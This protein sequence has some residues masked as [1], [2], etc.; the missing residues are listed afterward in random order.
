MS[1]ET[2]AIINSRFATVAEVRARS[3]YE[4]GG[5]Q[6]VEDKSDIASNTSKDVRTFL[7]VPS[8]YAVKT[9]RITRRESHYHWGSLWQPTQAT[10]SNGKAFIVI[11]LKERTTKTTGLF[12]KDP[13]KTEVVNFEIIPGVN[14]YYDSYDN[15]LSDGWRA[16][17]EFKLPNGVTFCA[18]MSVQTA[19]TLLG[20]SI[21]PGDTL[22]MALAGGGTFE[23]PENVITA[24]VSKDPFYSY[25]SSSYNHGAEP[26]FTKL[27]KPANQDAVLQYYIKNNKN[28]KGAQVLKG[29][30]KAWKR[31]NPLALAAAYKHPRA[32]LAYR[33]LVANSARSIDKVRVSV[34]FNN[35]FTK[36]VKTEEQF[37]KAIKPFL[38]AA[39]KSIAVVLKET[40]AWKTHRK[41]VLKS[42]T[43]RAHAKL[44]QD[45]EF[46]DVDS[47]T[48]PL[49]AKAVTG[50]EI[51]LSCFF[52]KKEQYFLFNDNWDLWEEM[53]KLHREETI[54]LA[55]EVSGRRQYQKD[56]MSYFYFVLYALPEYLQKNT[57]KPWIGVPKLVNDSSALDSSNLAQGTS[58]ERSAMTPT[59]DNEKGIVTVPFISVYM[60]GRFG[61]YCY[62]H[63]YN[64]LTRGMS[65]NGSTVMKD[66]EPRL[67]GKDDYGL[68]YYTLIGTARGNGYP[69][70][71]IIFERL[72]RGTRVHIHR[73]NPS[74]SKDGD[75]SPIHNWTKRCY[76]WMAGNVKRSRIKTSQGDLMFVEVNDEKKR[77]F[78]EK[79]NVFDSHAFDKAVPYCPRPEKSKERNLLGWINVTQET[80]LRHPEHE[81]RLLRAGVYEIRQA[82]SYENNPAGVW[83]LSID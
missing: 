70:F 80:W 17:A 31:V 56:L 83:T 49:T 1:L 59:V 41:K 5:G 72:S 60:P 23:L 19:E 30:Q 6:P 62:A 37:L 74:R 71:L 39:E 63:D 24:L 22:S 47:V 64:V 8:E 65:L 57:G 45:M 42:Q 2:T 40:E 54:K 29:V 78:P 38:G 3:H 28:A 52:S 35:T 14:R 79:V 48:H 33:N 15:L 66:L 76:N 61:T 67:N 58:R 34:V 11:T 77:E 27:C 68:M 13:V 7:K 82:R 53:L 12:K 69:T 4:R 51:P 21:S 50:G 9:Y 73:V 44:M 26:V 36:D 20:L 18:L 46:I 81:D 55:K 32:Y 25:S 10:I 43:K 16:L 75:Y